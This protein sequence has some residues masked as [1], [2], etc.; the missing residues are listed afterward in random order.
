MNAHPSDAAGTP[1]VSDAVPASLT[2][3]GLAALWR[4]VRRRLD[5]DGEA[6]ARTM[7]MPAIEPRC[8]LA[9]STLLERPTAARV[10]LNALEDG[11]RRRGIGHD[12]DSA[13]SRLGHPPDPAAVAARRARARTRRAHSALA[14]AAAGWPEPWAADWAEEL[15]SAGLIGSLD[16]PEVASLVDDVRR[17]LRHAADAPAGVTTR[18]QLAA[19]LFGSAH[20]LDDGTKLA[21]AAKRALRRTLGPSG[22][23]LEGRQL[24]EAAGIE[25][26]AVSAPVLTWGLRPIGSSPLA[27][28]L[29]S[30]ADSGM[31]L[32]LSLRLLRAHPIEVPDG[33]AVLVSENPSVIEAAIISKAPFGMVCTNGNPSTAVTELVTQLAASGAALSYHGDCDSDGIAICRRMAER[34]CVPWMMG[35]TDYLRALSHAAD[36]GIELPSDPNA[37]GPTPWD[38]DLAAEFA[39]LRS[40]V[41]EE[42]VV[43]ELLTAFAAHATTRR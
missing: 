13:L 14:D 34:G 20:A 18:A 6:T 41:H 21:S 36:N 33:T 31:P 9:L 7:A 12:L 43:D 10:D 39:A 30:A 15:R 17:L 19:R 11:L 27:S 16:E 28:M 24:W 3:P 25:V 23:V 40:V 37:C 38:P 26:D 2:D 22:Q 1:S 8:T 42:L 32:H 5:R 35:A 4:E 29:N